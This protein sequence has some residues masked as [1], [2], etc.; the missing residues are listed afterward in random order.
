MKIPYDVDGV[1][2][3]KDCKLLIGGLLSPD[4]TRRM[5]AV[6]IKQHGWFKTMNWDALLKKQI[7]A[8]W[9]PTVRS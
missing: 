5:S 7:T 4:P 3:S 2:I 6:A 9:V 8:P 1:S